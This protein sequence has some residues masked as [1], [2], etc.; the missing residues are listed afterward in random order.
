[1]ACYDKGN[2]IS[3]ISSISHRNLE[4]YLLAKQ[5]KVY[6]RIRMIDV[7]TFSVIYH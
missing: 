3:I 1:M 6:F 7:R 4:K 5:P 2:N